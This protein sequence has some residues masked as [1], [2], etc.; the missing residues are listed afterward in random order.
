MKH[1]YDHIDSNPDPAKT[2]DGFFQGLEIHYDKTR[3]KAWAE[4]DARLSQ[5]PVPKRLV[6]RPYRL[7][8]GIA[9]AVLL[10]AGIFSLFRFYQK[11]VYCPPGKHLSYIL[12]DGS[13]VEM[14]ADSKITFKPLWWRFARQINFEGEGYFEVEKGKKFGII[15]DFGRTEVLGT[16]FNI[17][18]RDSEYK[19]TCITGKVKVISFASAETILGPEYKAS[20]TSEGSITIS[21]EPSAD[22]T[23]AW[24]RNMFNFTASPLI[25]VLK[26]IGRQYDVMFNLKSGLDYSYTGYFSKDR[27]VEEVL[28][29]VCKPFGLTFIKISEKEF[30]IS[31]N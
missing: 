2:P 4:L 22:V 21:K 27:P 10:M 17:Y 29:L 16:S 6:F 19:V 3:E 15:S 28:T 9:A 7:T 14:N 18:S 31:Q 5:E 26:E 23:V 8:I 12:P 24:T 13:S 30:E 25:Q 11:A 20:I 1:S